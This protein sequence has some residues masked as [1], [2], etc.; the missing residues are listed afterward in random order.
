MTAE[1]VVLGVSG[2]SGGAGV[3]VGATLNGVSG[4][5][6]EAMSRGEASISPGLLSGTGT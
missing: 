6:S 5:T 2:A 3:G 1:R 4:S